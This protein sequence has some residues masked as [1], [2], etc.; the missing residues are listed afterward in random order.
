MVDDEVRAAKAKHEAVLMAR[1][2]VMA[3]AADLDRMLALELSECRLMSAAETLQRNADAAVLTAC[4]AAA[5]LLS[6]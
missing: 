5:P 3:A 4:N 1:R 2:I 6:C